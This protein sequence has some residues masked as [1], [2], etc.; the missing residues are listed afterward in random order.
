MTG[1]DDIIRAARVPGSLEPQSFGLW[2]IARHDMTILPRAYRKRMIGFDT[3]TILQRMT[4]ATMHHGKGG[5]EVVMEDSVRELRK[6]L[7]IFRRASGRVLVTGLGLG[8]VVRGLLSKPSVTHIDVVELDRDILRVVGA[9][10]AGNPRVTMHHGCALAIELPGP[11]NYA[12]HDLWVDDSEEDQPSLQVVH[13]KLF[14]KFVTHCGW[15]GA[16]HF[17]GNLARLLPQMAS[18]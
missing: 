11:W 6:H 7:P 2:H 10:F 9:E 5:W 17:P 4:L 3:Q 8:C 13:A 15:Q 18:A 1:D 12:W 16:W 14:V